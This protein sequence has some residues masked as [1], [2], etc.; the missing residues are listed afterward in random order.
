MSM[1]QKVVRGEPRGAGGVLIPEALAVLRSSVLIL[2]VISQREKQSGL[3][4]T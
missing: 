2:S 3:G 4:S 1:G